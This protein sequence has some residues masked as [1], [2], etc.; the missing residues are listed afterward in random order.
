M[1][2]NHDM[3]QAVS[4]FATNM[5][6]VRLSGEIA[7]WNPASSNGY[8][9][10]FQSFLSP[11]APTPHHLTFIV[12]AEVIALLGALH[13]SV[14]EYSQYIAFT[15][16]LSP[17]LTFLAGT[18]F[19][20]Q[21]FDNRA[22]VAL[23]MISYAFSSIGIWNS[24]WFYFQEPFTLFAVLGT[25]IAFL[26]KPSVSRLFLF[27]GAL[28]LQVCSANYWTIHNSWF[29]II[30][31]STFAFAFPNQVR[32]AFI[33]TM[34]ICR[35][36]Q[37]KAI[38]L[39]AVLALTVSLWGISLASTVSEQSA[40]HVRP[41]IGSGQYKMQRVLDRVRELRRSTLEFFNP[42]LDRALASYKYENDVH[43]ARYVGLVFLPFLMLLPFYA[44]RRKER[45]L[46]GLTVSTLMVCI[47]FPLLALLWTATP[48]LS[49]DQHLFYF[50]SQY[51]QL[52]VIMAAA[53]ALEVI[54]SSHLSHLAARRL[55]NVTLY[56]VTACFTA[57]V[58][59][60]LLSAQFPPNDL[61]LQTA[62]YSFVIILVTATL[63]AQHLLT[64]KPISK[65][66]LLTG[67]LAI[68]LLDLTTYFAH[69]SSKDAVFS[70]DYLLSKRY[71]MQVHEPAYLAVRTAKIESASDA[72]EIT[73]HRDVLKSP[74]AE[75][76]LSAGF[77]GG[78]FK[79]M[80]IFTD[81]WP[82]NR[83]LEPNGVIQF[84]AAPQAVQEYEYGSA[85]IQLASKL[86]PRY[87]STA[88]SSE[89][90]TN[91]DPTLD[92]VPEAGM[93]RHDPQGLVHDD[94]V[95]NFKYRFKS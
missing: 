12:W 90:F 37:S 5:H 53:A 30:T 91:D 32:R 44:W 34:Q 22:I 8:A 20:R 62:L 19:L 25:T 61:N 54:V 48:M 39:L 76:D 51:L 46:V 15:Y 59:C 80:P 63:A 1:L 95:A 4:F 86:D 16:A 71:R 89:P 47:G 45:W 92:Q 82:I 73:L 79:N 69:V 83:F 36:N 11:L 18:L 58:A 14:P 74:W 94:F 56:I 52:G 84:H 88:P 93:V 68:S 6:S 77:N 40:Q 9:Q 85:P 24:A 49:R 64:K 35:A 78:L 13:I 26:R 66:M 42:N 50:Y 38:Y 28:L 67:L 10:Y 23:L 70:H 27:V 87:D 75:P 17:F 43:N 31:A 60:N 55:S 41:T 7:F 21:I 3:S 65:T 81:F 29:L 72:K 33:W 57:F 2:P